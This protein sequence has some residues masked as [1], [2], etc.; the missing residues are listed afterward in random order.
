M[1]CSQARL[2]VFVPPLLH[3]P[4]LAA[5]PWLQARGVDVVSFDGPSVAE[6]ESKSHARALGLLAGSR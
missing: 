6:P 4:V 1:K 3:S 2:A 5:R